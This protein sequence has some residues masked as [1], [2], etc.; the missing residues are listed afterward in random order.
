M[1]GD[2]NVFQDKAHLTGRSTVG[3]GVFISVLVSS[4]NDNTFGREGYVD[5]NVRGATI[6]DGAMIGGGAALLPGVVIGRGAIVG[7]GAVVTR[8]VPAGATVMGVPARP[9]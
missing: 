6:E 9:R 3:N 2:E 1:V 7:S 8:D 5:E 4:T